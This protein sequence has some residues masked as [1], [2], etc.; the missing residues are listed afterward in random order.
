MGS[1]GIEEQGFLL[2]QRNSFS[3]SFSA[4]NTQ[5]V[6]DQKLQ[7]TLALGD[8]WGE[9]GLILAEPNPIPDGGWLFLVPWVHLEGESSVLLAAFVKDAD[10]LLLYCFV[11]GFGGEGG[12]KREKL[13]LYC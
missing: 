12:G 4:V 7:Q 3:R 10:K 2:S 6:P 8:G 11:L 5:A 9:W 13:V 1:S